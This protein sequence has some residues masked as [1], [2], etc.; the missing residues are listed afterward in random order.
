MSTENEVEEKVDEIVEICS[1]LFMK[2]KKEIDKIS[3][4]IDEIEDNEIKVSFLG[5]IV[6]I[7]MS[8]SKLSLHNLLGLLETLKIVIVSKVEE[9]ISTSKKY[10]TSYFA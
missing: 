6:Y 9:S 7:L 5:H 1:K 8:R 4:C 2:V 3:E 10:S